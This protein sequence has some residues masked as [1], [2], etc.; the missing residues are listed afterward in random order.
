MLF[1]VSISHT[2]IRNFFHINKHFFYL[3]ET[4]FLFPYSFRLIV[5]KNFTNIVNFEDIRKHFFTCW[6]LCC[7]LLPSSHCQN[8]FTN[9]HNLPI[10]NKQNFFLFSTYTP[11][12]RG[13]RNIRNLEDI[14]KTFILITPKIVLVYVV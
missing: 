8:Y 2:N 4:F 14:A 1:F 12:P 5:S 3:L 11:Y 7:F 6:K 9:I 13:A 10:P